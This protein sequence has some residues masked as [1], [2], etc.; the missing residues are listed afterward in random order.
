MNLPS[1]LLLLAGSLALAAGPV[2]AQTPSRVLWRVS[3]PGQFIPMDPVVGPDGTIYAISIDGELFAVSPDGQVKWTRPGMGNQGLDVDAQG[4]I[5]TG[6]EQ[7]IHAVNPKGTLRWTYDVPQPFP[8]V[9][10]GPAVG[11][12]GNIYAV[13]S[14]VSGNPGPYSLTPQGQLRWNSPIWFRPT[15]AF[16]Q[17]VFGPKPGGQQMVY[18]TG[19]HLARVDLVSGTLDTI[20][21]GAA[22][23]PVV[24]KDGN[25]Y[26]GGSGYDPLGNL[27]FATAN[28]ITGA[29]SDGTLYGSSL[30]GLFIEK[31]DPQTGALIWSFSALKGPAPVRPSPDD[32]YVLYGGHNPNVSGVNTFV[33]ASADGTQLWSEDL[34]IENG[35]TTVMSTA[36]VWAADHSRA[37]FGTASL[38]SGAVTHCYL[39]AIQATPANLE[40]PALAA[41]QKAAF[42]TVQGLPGAKV[43]FVFSLAG[44]GSAVVH[45]IPLGLHAPVSLIG[46]AVADAGGTAMLQRRVPAGKTGRQVWIQAVEEHGNATFG[47]TRVQTATIQ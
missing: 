18:V 34:P 24:N 16:S 21:G 40:P 7:H 29:A 36:Q 35:V 30:G 17:I 22:G 3:V 42:R 5:Y 19:S 39:Y 45:G 37:Y 38:A 13:G 11:P 6:D 1:R 15:V 43:F 28:I 4:I 9:S 8:I 10:Y 46:G 33:S 25:I 2:R 26:F 14:D 44:P 41:G 47:V 27:M 20:G 12:D 32:S 23:R 31:I